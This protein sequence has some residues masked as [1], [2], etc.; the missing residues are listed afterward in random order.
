[1]KYDFTRWVNSNFKEFAE[2]EDFFA[3]HIDVRGNQYGG[4]QT[5][6]DYNVTVDMAKHLCL[7]SKTEKG[8]QCRQRLIDLEDAWNTPEQGGKIDKKADGRPSKRDG[9]RRY[10]HCPVRPKDPV[11]NGTNNLK[12]DARIKGK[13]RR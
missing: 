13:R 9:V 2:N 7:M 3:G 12:K 1:M 8:K 11:K 6:D 5:V 4:T 10:L